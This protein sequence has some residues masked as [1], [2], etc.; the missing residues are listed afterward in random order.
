[1][2]REKDFEMEMMREKACE[3][4]VLEGEALKEQGESVLHAYL[5]IY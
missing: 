2:M 5:H 3:K 4:W 1:M